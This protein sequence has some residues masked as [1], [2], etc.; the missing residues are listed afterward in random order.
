VFFA[1]LVR[2]IG[3]LVNIVRHRQPSI[4]NDH[5]GGRESIVNDVVDSIQVVV[6][7]ASGAINRE[8]STLV[9][10]ISRERSQCRL[11]RFALVGLRW[12]P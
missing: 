8:R 9:A 4:V 11:P 6:N 3:F 7:D 5:G 12:V 1:C 10:E 2:R